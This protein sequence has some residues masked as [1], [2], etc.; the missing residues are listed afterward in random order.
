MSVNEVEAM[1]SLRRAETIRVYA[2]DGVYALLAD[3][4]DTITKM[5]SGDLSTKEVPLPEAERKKLFRT[6]SH[7]VLSGSPARKPL[8]ISKL[9]EKKS[10]SSLTTASTPP[11]AEPASDEIFLTIAVF[12]P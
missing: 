9:D 3:V 1:T 11:A 12:K 10:C 7:D 5:S 8:P 4:E 6:R 2:D